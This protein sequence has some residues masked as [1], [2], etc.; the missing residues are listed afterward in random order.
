MED[1]I[2]EYART[3][4]ASKFGAGAVVRNCERSIYNWAVQ[5]TRN[6]KDDPSWE[7]KRFRWRYKQKLMGLLSELER[8]QT[9][10]EVQL[11]P[12]DFGVKFSYKFVPQLV[13]RL[14]T[15]QLETKN[16]ARYSA[17]ILWPDGPKAKAIFKNREKDLMMEK[18]KAA[19]EN[20]NGLF[21]CRKCKSVK[22]SYYQMQTRSADEPMVRLLCFILLKLA[23]VLTPL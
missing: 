6:A 22:T 14:K 13:Y 19:E 10:I 9:C 16:L 12:T 23:R 7:N 2:R 4:F 5:E 15:K 21:K 11:T 8:D 20:Y 17:E 18:A 3:K 1:P